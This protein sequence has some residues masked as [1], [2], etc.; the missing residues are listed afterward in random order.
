MRY[1]GQNY[2]LALPF[3]GEKFDSKWAARLVDAFHNNHEFNYGF[4]SPEQSIQVVNLIVTAV[5]K[6]DVPD[7][8][9][10]AHGNEVAASGFRNVLFLGMTR[11][12]SPIFRR[13]YLVVGQKITG[14]AVIEQLDTTTVVFPGDS[15][16]VDQWGNLIMSIEE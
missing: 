6:L 9:L 4:A 2:E 13:E 5:A 11:H 12:R 3:E 14:P 15:C 16:T 1:V 10:A 8:P 7:L